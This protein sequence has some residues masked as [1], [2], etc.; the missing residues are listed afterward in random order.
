MH[1][2]SREKIF[3]M[4]DS[5]APTYDLVN[6]VMT[7][8]LDQYWRKKLVRSLPNEGSLKVLDCAT[9]TGDLVVA[10]MEGCPRITEM[11]GLDLAEEMVALAK[12]KIEGKPFA[13]KVAWQVGSAL[14][15]P[16][17]DTT[18]DVVTIA[19]GI[20][21]VT[22]V[23]LALNEFKRVLKPGGRLLILEAAL[24]QNNI[25]RSLHLFYLRHILP[26]V[27]GWIS[28]AKSAYR[29]LN[30]T[31]ETFPSGESFC[32]LMRGAGFKEVEVTGL[33]GGVVVVYSGVA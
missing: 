16:F 15:L 18:F 12:K 11:V 6:R 27:G 1:T 20:R 5:I 9:G 14:D 3:Q 26:R 2:P 10:M 23:S 19:F 13:S 7:F 31:I 4:F 22:D 17:A 30:E 28:G 21:N 24:P 29:Y 25:L 8:G 33:T 32:H